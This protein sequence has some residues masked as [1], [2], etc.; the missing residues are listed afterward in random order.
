M[1]M[2]LIRGIVTFPHDNH[3][4]PSNATW[5]RDICTFSGQNS[6]KKKHSMTQIASLLAVATV[7]IGFWTLNI[8]VLLLG[9]G[10]LIRKTKLQQELELKL[11]RGAYAQGGV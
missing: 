9:T 3:Y 4:R 8:Y 10:G 11:Q 1:G 6:R 5:V 2:E 7:F